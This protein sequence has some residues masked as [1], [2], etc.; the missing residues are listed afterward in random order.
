MSTVLKTEILREK[1]DYIA[2]SQKI[3]EM[4]AMPDYIDNHWKQISPL[5]NYTN[6]EENKQGVK[7]FW[8]TQ[9]MKQGRYVILSG[10]PTD[11]IEANLSEFLRWVSTSVVKP[12]RI[13]YALDILHSDFNPRVAASQ[14]QR[15]LAVTHAKSALQD[16]DILKGGFTQYV[17]TKTSE[18]YT[19]IYDKAAEQKT[20]YRW[21]RIETV[22]QGDRAE[23]SLQAYLQCQSTR[24]LIKRHVDFPK[25]RAWQR[26]MQNSVVKLSVPLRETRTRAWLLSQ[27]AKS[28]AREIAMD[29]DHAFWFELSAKVKSELELLTDDD[30][31]F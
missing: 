11:F 31:D 28:I 15:G 21:V 27:V 22:Y 2:Y 18:T 26:V 16:K 25:W 13:D 17:G 1:I 14:L 6:G 29:E 4:W 19:R 24:P 30:F 9:N 23:A 20:D 7:R 8:N 3:S 12:T 5:R 10:S